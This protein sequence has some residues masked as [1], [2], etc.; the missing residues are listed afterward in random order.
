MTL[1]G[2]LS[3]H[4]FYFTMTGE[5]MH[6]YEG[7]HSSA[8]GWRDSTVKGHVGHFPWPMTIEQAEVAITAYRVKQRL[9]S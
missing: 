2:Y 3:A 8:P 1:G 7:K 5:H 9:M 6:I 4:G